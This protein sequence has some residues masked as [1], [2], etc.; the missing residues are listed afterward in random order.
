MPTYQTLK[1]GWEP[2]EHASIE[3]GAVAVLRYRK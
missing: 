3:Q 2:T 1:S